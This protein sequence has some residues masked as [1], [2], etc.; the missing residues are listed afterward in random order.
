MTVVNLVIL[1]QSPYLS[2]I[3]ME[4]R[5]K[6][7]A[8][9]QAVSLPSLASTCPKRK[10]NV[11]PDAIGCNR[12][13]SRAADTSFSSRAGPQQDGMGWGSGLGHLELV[14]LPMQRLL[15]PSL[16]HVTVLSFSYSLSPSPSVEFRTGSQ[17]ICDIP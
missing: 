7:E 11:L 8:M 15:P 13:P 14:L 10:V 4:P 5:T 16:W 2:R 3:S 6:R 12:P 17:N 1:A 9:H